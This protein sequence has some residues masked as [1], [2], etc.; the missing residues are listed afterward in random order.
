MP[1]LALISNTE[2][3]AGQRSSSESSSA[4]SIS[5]TQYLQGGTRR[6]KAVSSG[7]GKVHEGTRQYKNGSEQYRQVHSG[8]Y[9]FDFEQYRQVHTGTFAYEYSC[10]RLI[11]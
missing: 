9:W 7:T 8:T 4:K 10:V 1:V 3:Q 11:F 2:L 5:T 6:Y